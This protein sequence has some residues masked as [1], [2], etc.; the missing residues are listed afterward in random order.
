M[1]KHHDPYCTDN[2]GYTPLHTAADF[3][4][5]AIVK[6][7]I[8]NLSLD[9]NCRTGFN[10][11][12][13]VFHIA[14][15]QGME[16]V[17]KYLISLKKCD[18]TCVDAM[19]YTGLHY[20]IMNGHCNIVQML[21]MGRHC[22]ILHQDLGGSTPLERA[23]AQNQFDCVKVLVMALKKQTQHFH[24]HC[25]KSFSLACSG[26]DLKIVAYLYKEIGNH[27][28]N[29][30]EIVRTAIS[31]NQLEVVDFLLTKWPQSLDSKNWLGENLL[32]TAAETGNI[33]TVKLLLAKFSM[34]PNSLNFRGTT[35]LHTACFHGNHTIIKHLASWCTRFFDVEGRT[36]LHHA[37]IG[38]HLHIIKEL[39]TI[40]DYRKFRF[41]QDNKGYT[42]CHS[43]LRQGYMYI[44]DFFIDQL[45]QNSSVLLH[46]EKDGSLLSN[47]PMYRG[48][49]CTAQLAVHRA[50]F[51]GFIE[52]VKFLIER[53]S[54]NPNYR[55][56]LGRTALHYAAMSNKTEIVKYLIKKANCLITAED[57]F[58]NLPLHY[59][60]AKGSIGS[61]MFLI[62]NGSPH[63]SEGMLHMTPHDM[64]VAGGH[65]LLQV[66]LKVTPA[67]GVN[68]KNFLKAWNF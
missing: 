42:P 29:C 30:N 24:K 56:R 14:C 16:A 54:H 43:A 17:V 10:T 7:F 2:R 3:G 58:H 13:T 35:P 18:K 47:V 23:V 44:V 5:T 6:W 36:P 37:A 34:N 22:D 50:A 4:H 53:E 19:N 26:G 27:I 12:L 61:A 40:K 62:A 59:A 32:H 21:C 45:K 57:V 65:S 9:P 41:H 68:V 15:K 52:A 8:N 11:L 48:T 33:N 63:T 60:A 49:I 31:N 39:L 28:S 38:G 51:N 66:V 64:A 25:V 20:A 67:S 55:D 1:Q 46:R